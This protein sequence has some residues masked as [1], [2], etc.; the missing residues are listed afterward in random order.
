[1]PYLA[2]IQPTHTTRSAGSWKIDKTNKYI[3]SGDNS[4]GERQLYSTTKVNVNTMAWVEEI[5]NI[6]MK[7][8]DLCLEIVPFKKFNCI[9]HH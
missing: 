3:N 4:A 8:R 6:F 7:Q 1:M 9:R 5:S 2:V